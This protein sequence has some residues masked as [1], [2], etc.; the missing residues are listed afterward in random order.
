MFVLFK[1]TNETFFNQHTKF[2]VNSKII[3]NNQKSINYENF[4]FKH[5]QVSI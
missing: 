4:N 1:T 2:S 3:S 5:R